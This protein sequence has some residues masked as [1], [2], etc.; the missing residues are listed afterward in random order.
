MRENKF[1]VWTGKEYDYDIAI[2]DGKAYS[3]DCGELVEPY[4]NEPEQYTGLKDKNGVEIFEGDIVQVK[5]FKAEI[6]YNVAGF[7]W[8][9]LESKEYFDAT[10]HDWGYKSEVIGN[11][12]EA[13][14]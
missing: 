3:P 14:K 10:F 6:R 12:H 11:I 7:A 4:E 1:R 9:E 5:T 8:F 2:W 13:N